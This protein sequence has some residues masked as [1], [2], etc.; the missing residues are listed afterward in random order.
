MV[1]QQCCSKE[2]PMINFHSK[3]TKKTIATTIVVIVVI[4]TVLTLI[5]PYMNF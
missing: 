2:Y 1:S 3:K 5:L 4:A